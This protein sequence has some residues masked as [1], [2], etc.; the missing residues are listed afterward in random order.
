MD[1]KTGHDQAPV[2]VPMIIGRAVM[3][4]LLI[5]GLVTTVYVVLLSAL[6]LEAV[7]FT[8]VWWIRMRGYRKVANMLQEELNQTPD[9]IFSKGPAM[10]MVVVKGHAA[11]L[12]YFHGKKKIWVLYCTVKIDQA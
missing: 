2:W 12:R 6:C 3:L 5:F 1:V 9:S 11:T 4:I 7:V 10:R 8:F